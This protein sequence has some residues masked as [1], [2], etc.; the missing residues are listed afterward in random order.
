MTTAAN[1]PVEHAE[2]HVPD[3]LKDRLAALDEPTSAPPRTKR[4]W[5]PVILGVLVLGIIGAGGYWGWHQINSP[6]GPPKNLETQSLTRGDIVLTFVEKGELEAARNTEIICQVRASGRGNSAASS[7]KWV[8]DDGTKV[9][10]GDLLM[11]LEDASLREQL[12]NQ[13]IVVEEKNDLYEQA[14]ANLKIVENENKSAELTAVN[15]F[16]LAEI[17][18]EKFRKAER[19]QKQFDIDSRIKLASAD[20]IQW[21]D[22]LGWSN[23]MFVRGYLS[24]NQKLNDETRLDQANVNLDKLQKEF[25]TLKFDNQRQELDL[26]NKLEQA[27]L[28]M[29]IAKEN[30]ESKRAQGQAKLTS[31]DLILKQESQKRDDLEQDLRNCK[32]Y[33]PHDGM[34]IYF[35]PE[36]SRFGGSSQ[37]SPIE[38]GSPVKEGQKLMRI[39]NL[40]RMIARVKVHE[41]I[42]TKLRGD[43]TAPTGFGTAYDMGQVMMQWGHLIS[44]HAV[45]GHH[46]ALPAFMPGLIIQREVKSDLAHLEEVIV[47]DGMLASIKVSSLEKPL[48]GHVKMVSSVASSTD[49][50]SA[51]VKVYQTVVAID[52]TPENLK[53]NMS[54]EV[55][56]KIDERK[57]VLQLPIQA[58]LESGGEKFCY[59]KTDNAI[60]KRTVKTGLNNYKFVEILPESKVKEG[61]QIVLNSRSYAEKVNDLKGNVNIDPSSGIRDRGN[62][63]GPGKMP[64]KSTAQ[65]PGKTKSTSPDKTAQQANGSETTAKGTK[66]RSAKGAGN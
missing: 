24:A 7:I 9:K 51:D 8:I 43:T 37:T 62:R 5:T 52:D 40:S 31:A 54:A 42:V 13:H 4:S 65:S 28:Q 63:K 66:E 41:S 20:L 14:K 21:R 3:E 64:G 48:S 44:A 17:D 47:D 15:N 12:N 11:L 53:P 36:S 26:L 50:M 34:V 39:P 29:E 32:I 19:Q 30:S 16:K 45:P 38:V 27:K 61:E 55:T 56:V 57:G 59:V 22:K 25:D 49:W 33:A 46:S 23:R 60:E 18:L 10:K 6:V 58:V 1:P 35:I 2:H